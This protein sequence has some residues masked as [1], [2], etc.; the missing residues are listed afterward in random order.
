M[1][2]LSFD[3]SS[4]SSLG[5][6][7]AFKV[8][9]PDIGDAAAN[10]R[11]T[12]V[13]TYLDFVYIGTDSGVV[14]CYAV[15]SQ[16]RGG[17][18]REWTLVTRKRVSKRGIS[19]FALMDPRGVGT[20]APSKVTANVRDETALVFVQT[21]DGALSA[22]HPHTL[23]TTVAFT[24][25]NGVTV[26]AVDAD[27]P[28]N[29]I[30]H[31]RGRKKLLIVAY[32]L[33]SSGGLSGSHTVVK[34][35]PFNDPPLSLILQG[36][37]CAMATRREYLLLNVSFGDVR[38]CPVPLDGGIP[39]MCAVGRN[40]LLVTSNSDLG[41]FV[42]FKGDPL[43]RNPIDWNGKPLALTLCDHF[44]C[45]IFDDSA[46]QLAT[47]SP[48]TSNAPSPS[49]ARTAAAA[50]A[51]MSASGSV[52]IASLLDQRIKQSVAFPHPFSI[53]SVKDKVVVLSSSAPFIPSVLQ[54]GMTAPQMPYASVNLSALYLVGL[55]EQIAQF[56]EAAMTDEAFA[57]LMRTRPSAERIAEFHTNAGFAMLKALFIPAAFT[58]FNQ[59]NLDPREL[60]VLFP[61]LN[62]AG[63]KYSSSWAAKV[64]TFTELMEHGR[65]TAVMRADDKR[66][67]AI[68][69][70]SAKQITRQTRFLLAAFL[71]DKRSKLVAKH[72]DNPDLMAPMDTA[73]LVL[74]ID[75][76]EEPMPS[77]APSFPY[78]LQHLLFPAN[79]CALSPCESFLTV[80]RQYNALALLYRSVGQKRAALDVWARMGSGQFIE[81]NADADHVATAGVA[82]TVALLSTLEDEPLL[83]EFAEWVLIRSA[84]EGLAVFTNTNRRTPLTAEKVLAYLRRVNTKLNG[85]EDG[86]DAGGGVDM[87]ELYLE[88]LIDVERTSD[89]IY[90]T[91]LA[92]NYIRKLAGAVS[93][94]GTR[95]YRQK[96]FRF[97]QS[98]DFLDPH[99]IATAL[100][101]VAF[102]PA[103]NQTLNEDD[104]VDGLWLPQAEVIFNTP[105]IVYEELILL[106]NKLSLHRLALKLYVFGLRDHVGASNYCVAV[107]KR[108]AA[109]EKEEQQIALTRA[110]EAK[111]VEEKTHDKANRQ[112]NGRGGHDDDDDLDDNNDGFDDETLH[113][114][115]TRADDAVDDHDRPHSGDVFIA[116][117]DQYFSADFFG[118]FATDQE[119]TDS[120]SSSVPPP[121]AYKFAVDLLITHFAAIDVVKA[122]RSIPPWVPLGPLTPYFKRIIPLVTHCRRHNRLVRQLAKTF[123]LRVQTRFLSVRAN[124]LSVDTTTRCAYCGKLLGDSFFTAHPVSSNHPDFIHSV[125]ATRPL[126]EDEPRRSSDDGLSFVLVHSACSAAYQIDHHNKKPRTQNEQLTKRK[127]AA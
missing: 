80:H 76:A 36:E 1:S 58:H 87:V 48:A 9:H 40:E 42:N 125:K 67:K 71:W 2:S 53:A 4:S 46:S 18:A 55:E 59:S 64:G 49:K 74:H 119:R 108:A 110:E 15:S 65:K 86:S 105:P 117:S 106:F 72:V 93:T 23:D 78:S 11:I 30:A 124:Q 19:A 29:V 12:A 118:L 33:Q 98:S 5:L 115:S 47:G 112:R 75:F 57:L 13:T 20:A 77:P 41:I 63:S 31:V 27:S 14:I 60:I 17:G 8:A 22:L 69:S 111:D 123:H 73:M 62:I 35:I 122:V 95:D 26:F 109:R 61:D 126:R 25:L 66:Y 3:P 28:H 99:Q 50:A 88:Y 103:E 38:P 83:W 45:A 114:V 43:P 34:E 24:S 90:H 54:A 113:D 94:S 6:L 92:L 91:Q 127:I 84:T 120:E 79:A 21:A 68:L 89:A 121:L 10:G 16:S 70:A 104:V 39:C 85:G 82:E 100:L 116:L 37:W 96:L 32:T 102:G 51:G 107:S 7:D 44:V 81:R 52:R 56:M 101:Q 97:L